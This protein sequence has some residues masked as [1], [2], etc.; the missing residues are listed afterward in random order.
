M[1]VTVCR[2]EGFEESVAD[3]DCVGRKKSKKLY[4]MCTSV[5][6]SV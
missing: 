5:L 1:F 2:T 6:V 3:V 4:P